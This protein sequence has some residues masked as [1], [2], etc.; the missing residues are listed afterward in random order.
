MTEEEL[1]QKQEELKQQQAELKLQ[2]QGGAEDD[3][4]DESNNKDNDLDETGKDDSTSTNSLK[5]D[6]LEDDKKIPYSRFKDKVDEVNRLS[7]KLDEI[8][9]SQKEQEKQKLEEQEQYKELY[10]KA[11]EEIENIK[12]QKLQDKIETELKSAGYKEEQ[13]T[14]LSKLVEG[15]TDE[16]ITK[17]IEDLKITFPTKT[18]VDPSPDQRK[19]HKPEG[20]DGDDI[21]KSMFERLK[22][23]GKLKGFK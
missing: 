4:V 20:V 6:V 21:G 8:E 1:R 2:Q 15:E 9:K 14:R 17:S 22:E 23:A 5:D 3:P 11:Q 18:Y 7:A 16:E 12:S 19:R 13:V 10:E